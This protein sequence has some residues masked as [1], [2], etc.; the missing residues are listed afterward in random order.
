MKNKLYIIRYRII[1][2]GDC[3]LDLGVQIC[4]TLWAVLVFACSM[5]RRDPELDDTDKFY[6]E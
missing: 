4:M 3:L 5:F 1:G 6:H 2:V